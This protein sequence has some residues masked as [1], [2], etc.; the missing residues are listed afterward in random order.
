VYKYS[1]K[2]YASAKTPGHQLH[3]MLTLRVMDG[4]PEKITC[5]VEMMELATGNTAPAAR[6]RSS[7]VN[8]KFIPVSTGLLQKRTEITWSIHMD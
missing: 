8:R 6:S 3:L 7:S 1:G 2:H 5:A 4:S